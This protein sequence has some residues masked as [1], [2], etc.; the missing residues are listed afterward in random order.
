[1]QR[2]NANANASLASPRVRIQLGLIYNQRLEVNALKAPPLP[3][4]SLYQSPSLEVGP[5][6]HFVYS[7]DTISFSVSIPVSV[8]VRVR[9]RF[10]L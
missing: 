5:H 4:Y 3:L 10:A 8:P 6:E 2:A 9:V 7:C 1:M